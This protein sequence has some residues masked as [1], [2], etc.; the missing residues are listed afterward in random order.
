MANDNQEEANPQQ[1]QSSHDCTNTM[2]SAGS[3]KSGTQ[4]DPGVPK[5]SDGIKTRVIVLGDLQ[6]DSVVLEYSPSA[7]DKQ[8][9]VNWRENKQRHVLSI[10]RDG[11]LW[12]VADAI[13]QAAEG[14]QSDANAPLK[15][16]QLRRPPMPIVAPVIVAITAPSL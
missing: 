9:P 3:E 15:F 4:P 13:L 10:R 5:G 12:L 14:V 2:E 8:V 16:F 11:G 7:S 6:T 1:P